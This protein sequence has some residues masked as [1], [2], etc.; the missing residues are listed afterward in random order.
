MNILYLVT[1]CSMFFLA[2]SGDKAVSIPGAPR[3]NCTGTIRDAGGALVAGARVLL[4]PQEYSRKISG[5]VSDDLDST[6]TNDN[7]QYGFSVDAPGRYNVLAK[8]NN[9]L[10]MHQAVP[11]TLHAGVEL[12]DTLREAGSM[13]GTIRLQ[14]A[15]DHRSAFVL[16]IGTNFYTTPS[17]TSGDFTVPQLAHG[18]YRL[19]VLTAGRDFA[20]K[21]TTVTV[22]SGAHTQLPVIELAKSAVPMTDSLLTDYN[23][24]M[25]TVTVR[26]KPLDTA[27]IGGYSIYCNR[28]KNLAPVLTVGKSC[29]THTFD[30]AYSPVDT[31]TYQVAAVGK[32][33]VEGTALSGRTF[34]TT[35]G[36]ILTKTIRY[37]SPW[38]EFGPGGMYI[39]HWG[40]IYLVGSLYV[41][42]LD[43][44]GA[45]LAKLGL[46]DDTTG[47][48]CSDIQ[49]DDSG[50]I[51]IRK[52]TPDYLVR[53]DKNL[54]VRA[55]LRVD[56]PY[57]GFSFAVSRQGS[58]LIRDEMAVYDSNL[59]RIQ[60]APDDGRMI[61]SLAAN[62]GDTLV[63]VEDAQTN[64][65]TPDQY[66]LVYSDRCF[67]VTS[68]VDDFDYVTDNIPSDFI[69]RSFSCIGPGGLVGASFNELSPTVG[70]DAM[71]KKTLMAFFTRTKI[72]GRIPATLFG[73]EFFYLM[74]FSKSGDLYVCPREGE[75]VIYKYSAELLFKKD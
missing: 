60:D 14:G 40:N 15:R 48:F 74:A 21:E 8:K 9:L 1:G 22:V 6:V 20:M 38:P 49:G 28:A 12:G 36:L 13:S 37:Q 73:K 18:T 29:S 43:S 7:G 54:H 2:C 35:P 66:N 53:L 58:V 24:A 41:Y 30:L 65:G 3:G 71:I 25:M 63:T 69:F 57:N 44:T 19:R 17:D 23:P 51:Y 59:T 10:S 45:L 11:I 33:G 34:V 68:R 31:F 47:Y 26:W 70:D 75:P 42:K 56:L 55:Q 50:N 52:E 27:L 67:A 62:F 72:V 5:G 39:D 61:I 4:V 32:N 64:Y 16:F 46:P